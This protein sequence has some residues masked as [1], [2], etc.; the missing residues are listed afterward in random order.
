MKNTIAFLFLTAAIAL[1]S[2]HALAT[3]PERTAGENAQPAQAAYDTQNLAGFTMKE[4][5]AIYD[6][7][8]LPPFQRD[9]R[10]DIRFRTHAGPDSLVNSR[11]SPGVPRNELPVRLARKLNPPKSGTKIVAI[12]ADL[13]MLDLGSL[14]IVD[15]VP[16]VI[17][18][19][20]R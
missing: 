13:V 2:M 5:Q 12:D 4:R 15:V 3:A 17:P 1:P 6:Y 10:E 14:Q 16:N 18:Q 9:I 20:T 19:Y 7:Y 11:L 8:D